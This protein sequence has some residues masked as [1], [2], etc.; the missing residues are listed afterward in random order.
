MHIQRVARATSRTPPQILAMHVFVRACMC[1]LCVRAHAHA[2]LAQLRQ[3][4]QEQQQQAAPKSVGFAGSLSSCDTSSSMT[5]A[6]PLTAPARAGSRLAAGAAR[7]TAKPAAR[8]AAPT[9]SVARRA[10]R[11][12]VVDGGWR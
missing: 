7:V 4:R 11:A 8:A 10:G 2:G 12:G 5:R 6:R 3:S 1:V 9:P